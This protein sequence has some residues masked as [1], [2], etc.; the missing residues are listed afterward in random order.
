M[1]QFML[2]SDTPKFQMT[3]ERMRWVLKYLRKLSY[4]DIMRASDWV[5]AFHATELWESP[6]EDATD[7]QKEQL[8]REC[9]RN[10]A[11]QIFDAYDGNYPDHKSRDVVEFQ[12]LEMPYVLWMTG[13][14][15]GGD[16]PTQSY[17]DWQ[18]FA[19]FD[20]LYHQFRDWAVQDYR[21]ERI[22]EISAHGSDNSGSDA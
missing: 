12:I 4:E 15:S 2:L 19:Y 14:M 3:R 8:R 11:R 10:F 22:K 20:S 1:G 21:T 13:G 5:D 18:G 17:D 9:I 16:T 7:S 6:S